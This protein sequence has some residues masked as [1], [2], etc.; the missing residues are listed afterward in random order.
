MHGDLSSNYP[1]LIRLQ[2]SKFR[3]MHRFHAM[4][5]PHHVSTLLRLKI[6]YIMMLSYASTCIYAS[7]LVMDQSPGLRVCFREDR[8]PGP[9]CRTK[10]VTVCVNSI[11]GKPYMDY[12]RHD[13]GVLSRYRARTC[14]CLSTSDNDQQ[15]PWYPQPGSGRQAE[16]W[17]SSTKYSDASLEPCFLKTGLYFQNIPL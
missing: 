3:S 15:R 5:N 7:S 9:R 13:L 8:V 14:L 4:H 16:R 11:I 12:N 17:R 10:S 1:R 6:L 2:E